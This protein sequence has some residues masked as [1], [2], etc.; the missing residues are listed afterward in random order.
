MLGLGSPSTAAPAGTAP[1]IAG[2]NRAAFAGI[3]QGNHRLHGYARIDRAALAEVRQRDD[4]LYVVSWIDRT[5]LTEV[6]QWN[7]R[8]YVISWID[9]T[10]LAGIGQRDDRLPTGSAHRGQKIIKITLI[11]KIGTE[12]PAASFQMVL[13]Y[14]MRAP[15]LRCIAV[16]VP[17]VCINIKPQKL[18]H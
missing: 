15:H 4:R 11:H 14:L 12:V 18:W 7:H 16:L 8:P 17:P 13:Y 6:G 10:A 5:T 3:G 2:V 1:I 9:R